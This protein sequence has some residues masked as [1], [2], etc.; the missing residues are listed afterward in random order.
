LADQAQVL[1]NHGVFG[2]FERGLRRRH[3]GSL[4]QRTTNNARHNSSGKLYRHEVKKPE[5]QSAAGIMKRL[6]KG[7][8]RMRGIVSQFELLA[9]VARTC[10]VGPRLCIVNMGLPYLLNITACV[11]GE[12]S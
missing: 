7:I 9:R 10:S 2:G 11:M 12:R 3:V 8:D 1:L 5:K 6:L 4:Y